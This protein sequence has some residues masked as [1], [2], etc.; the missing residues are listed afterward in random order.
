MRAR[1][2]GIDGA[3]PGLSDAGRASA[4]YVS[5]ARS[6]QRTGLSQDSVRTALLILCAVLW[7]PRPAAAA[8]GAATLDRIRERGAITMG[9][10]QD[11]RPFSF[12]GVDQQP[13][14]YAVDLCREIAREIRAQPGLAGI[15]ERWV[16]L[17]IQNRLEA[18]SR[19]QVDIECS[20]TTWT[21]ARNATVDF[22]LITFVDGG[23]VLTRTEARLSRLHDLDGRRVAV[24]AGTTTEKALRA[25]FVQRKMVLD[26]ITVANR[27]EGLR[28]LDEGRVEGF[29]AD[30]TT[31][32][33]LLEGAPAPGSDRLIDEDFSIE[34]YAL[35]LAR[36]DPEFRLAVN[37]VLARLY[38]DG[39]IMR[40]YDHWLGRLGP[41]SLLLSAAYF[42]QALE[43]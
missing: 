4:R 14:G 2:V 27:A 7:M 1:D 36:G 17:T 11:A 10:V 19:G 3:T 26:A 5:D 30:R 8:D 23:S 18:V 39:D 6:A 34:R 29:A 15:E 43:D 12:L 40:I 9:Y 28:L 13:Q 38:R 35:A 32:I 20:T 25:S 37:R 21:L 33:G 22:S 41:P 16:P 42:V 24:I 31:L